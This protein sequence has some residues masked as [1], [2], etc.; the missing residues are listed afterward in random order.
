MSIKKIVTYVS[1]IKVGLIDLE[2]SIDS[3]NIEINK[4]SSIQELFPL[5]SDPKFK[6]DLVLIDIDSFYDVQDTSIFDITHSLSTLIKCTVCRTGLGKPSRRVTHLAAT[7]NLN[8]DVGLIKE[9]LLTDFKGLYPIGETFA[10]GEKQLA[11]DDLLAGKIHIPKK[12]TKLLQPNKLSSKAKNNIILTP[13]QKQIADLIG[14][15]GASNKAIAKILDLSESTVKLH[16]SALLKKY[17]VRTRTQLAVFY[18]DSIS[19]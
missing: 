14:I 10:I 15:R 11:L 9:I 5:L 4:I 2:S 8:T 3:T 19:Q 1:P 16:V 6:T 18:K 12:I 7:V 13:R 17:G